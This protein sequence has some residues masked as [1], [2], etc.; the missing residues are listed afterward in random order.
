MPINAQIAAFDSH[1]LE[2]RSRKYL[3]ITR[4]DLLPKASC[5]ALDCATSGDAVHV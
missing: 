2:I 1:Q 3:P 4:D 5:F